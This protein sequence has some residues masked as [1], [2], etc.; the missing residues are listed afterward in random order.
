[1]RRV[2]WQQ[3]HLAFV[4]VDVLEVAVVDGLKEHSPL[5]LVEPFR[6]LVDMIICS[7]IWTAD[8]LMILAR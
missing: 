8:N 2:W 7:G 4:D 3:K 6:R 1:M 5:V